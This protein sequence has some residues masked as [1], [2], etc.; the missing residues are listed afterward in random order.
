MG[1]VVGS[2]CHVPTTFACARALG[3]IPASA[4]KTKRAAN[5]IC[6][7]IIR[8]VPRSNSRRELLEIGCTERY[9][10]GMKF[11]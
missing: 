10:L 7:A 8:E 11:S 1:I 6:G 5:A 3:A 9:L 2:V 4:A